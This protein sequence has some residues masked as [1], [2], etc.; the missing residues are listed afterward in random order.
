LRRARR[1]LERRLARVPRL[2]K[3]APAA[4][5][6]CGPPLWVDDP[7]FSIA[8]HVK[9][10]ALAP[11]GDDASLLNATEALL[12][13]LL[14]R[15]HPL[16]ELWFLTGQEGGEFGMLFKVHH[17]VADGLAAVALLMAFLDLAPD[18]PD[19]PLV[20]WT[21]APGPSTWALFTDNMRRWQDS[22]LS[23]LAH[24]LHLMRSAGWTLADSVRL[25]RLSNSAPRTSLNALPRLQRRIRVMRVELEAARAVAHA[26]NA[27]VND[28]VL[29]VVSGGVRE[30]LM[31]RGEPV[32]GLELTLRPRQRC[33]PPWR[34]DN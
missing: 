13:P 2:R 14:D 5:T 28:V 7:A 32:Y 18:A 24:P 10:K 12:R 4:P 27:Q 23:A 6:L 8:R 31:A 26:R 29:T 21:P 30:L 9:S 34:P 15:A 16:W 25:L 22:L 17:A 20:A 11:P 33:D 1:R 3:I 19:P